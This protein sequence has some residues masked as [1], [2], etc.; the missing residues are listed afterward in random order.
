M[1]HTILLKEANKRVGRFPSKE[2]ASEYLVGYIK[3]QQHHLDKSK[4][5]PFYVE[6]EDQETA[7][8][9]VDPQSVDIVE[10]ETSQKEEN[11]D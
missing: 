8:Y 11:N 1:T 3:M 2:S 7:I 5:I 4:K 10:M 6:V 9:W